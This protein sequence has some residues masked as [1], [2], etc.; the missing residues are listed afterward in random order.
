VHVDDCILFATLFGRKEV[1][2]RLSFHN[3]YGADAHFF[4]RAEQEFVVKK[5]DLRTY[6]YYRNNINSLTARIKSER[7]N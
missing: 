1:F 7:S 6:V 4:E 5:L 2:T 3:M